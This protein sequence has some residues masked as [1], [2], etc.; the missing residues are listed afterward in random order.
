MKSRLFRAVVIAGGV[1]IQATAIGE[2]DPAEN[3]ASDKI[4]VP[5]VV[6][7]E[8]HSRP[9]FCSW[10]IHWKLPSSDS[11]DSQAVS[12]Q[13]SPGINPA[14]A[15]LLKRQNALAILASSIAWKKPWVGAGWSIGELPPNDG[16]GYSA[17]LSAGLIASAARTAFPSEVC[18]L[19][20][21]DADGCLLPVSHPDLRLSTAAAHG[22]QMVIFSGFQRFKGDSKEGW[23]DLALRAEQLGVSCQFA[24][25]LSEAIRLALDVPL[26]SPQVLKSLSYNRSI[27]KWLDLSFHRLSENWSSLPRDHLVPSAASEYEQAISSYSAGALYNANRHLQ[28]ALSLQAR[29]A[30][31]RAE[32]LQE[33]KKTVDENKTQG[34]LP[35]HES[36]THPNDPVQMLAFA[37]RSH[38]LNKRQTILLHARF[39]FGQ[40]DGA[41]TR[42]SPDRSLLE[43]SLQADWIELQSNINSLDL[44]FNPGSMLD[45]EQ[46][47]ARAT[48]L[49]PQ[50]RA[51]FLAEAEEIT[52]SLKTQSYPS[53]HEFLTDAEFTAT[54]RAITREST[55]E[56]AALAQW[57]GY[58]NRPSSN[59]I[60]FFPS[61]AFAP[62]SLPP[63]TTPNLNDLAQVALLINE[64]CDLLR[65][66]D[67]YFVNQENPPNRAFWQHK[68]AVLS[69]QYEE[70]CA[71]AQSTGADISVLALIHEKASD[72]AFSSNPNDWLD[73]AVE[74][75][76][77]F[78]LGHFISE[79]FYTPRALPSAPVPLI[80]RALPV[81]ETNEP[82]TGGSVNPGPDSP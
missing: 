43:S 27:F 59:I 19:S 23:T 10:Q 51:L 49:L 9:E 65:I 41:I 67:Q 77:G 53:A 18:L 68:L 21:V 63:S 73:A 57:Q 70:A 32:W 22:I 40:L 15:D 72:L 47:Q 24:D 30:P 56:Q 62:I 1:L 60:G 64:Y 3:P 28:Y 54:A 4:S 75:R 37:E 35:V 7:N 58:D 17:A 13:L 11:G 82:T 61:P 42:N 33:L 71:L 79:L 26:Q 45:T 78:L 66:R 16:S 81:H 44:S 5:V 34:E 12:L 25:T 39:L 6:W 74:F 2:T 36:W 48:L 8:T 55:F 69:R 46:A 52:K 76:R 31:P 38:L 14:D 20:D 29:S 80:A 50:W